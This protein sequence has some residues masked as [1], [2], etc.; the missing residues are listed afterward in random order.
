[1]QERRVI[2]VERG[3]GKPS[4]INKNW[5]GLE[6]GGV[7]RRGLCRRKGISI[8]DNRLHSSGREKTPEKER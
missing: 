2:A 1:M 4:V 7:I 3:G 5:R 8:W 6:E